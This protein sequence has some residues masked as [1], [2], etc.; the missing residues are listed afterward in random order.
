MLDAAQK[1]DLSA[2]ILVL[3]ADNEGAKVMG[4]E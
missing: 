1:H 3:K 2:S 4:K